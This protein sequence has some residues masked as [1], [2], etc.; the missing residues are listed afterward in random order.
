MKKTLTL[1][2]TEFEANPIESICGILEFDPGRKNMRL[3]APRPPFRQQD[4]ESV[5]Q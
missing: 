5:V 2:M 4:S 1:L 3:R